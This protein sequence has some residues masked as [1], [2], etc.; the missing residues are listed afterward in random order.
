MSVRINMCDQFKREREMGNV[1]QLKG[2]GVECWLITPIYVDISFTL[3][4]INKFKPLLNL[5]AFTLNGYPS[6][7]ICYIPG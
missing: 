1:L 4:T 3:S 7:S 2:G 6:L 5:I